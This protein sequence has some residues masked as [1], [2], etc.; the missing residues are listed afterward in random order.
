MDRE[1]IRDEVQAR[2]FDDVTDA[3]VNTWINA[4]YFRICDLE[5]WPFLEASTTGTAPLTI[6]DF[7]AGLSII[8]TTNDNPLVW[9]DP[10][11]IREDDPTLALTGTPAYWYMSGTSLK[12][13][14][15]NTAASLNVSYLKVPEELDGDTDI[16]LIPTRY[17]YVLV[18]WVV[19]EAYKDSD[20]FE[21]YSNLRPIADEGLQQIRNA[22]LID[23]FDSTT[24]ILRTWG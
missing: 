17:H 4:A 6:S 22:L 5:A 16:P 3:R 2:G 18:D 7:R 15:A 20:N 9:A 24:E 14:P 10:R 1:D 8:D 13:Y 23:H 11:T 21:A 12:V 19:L